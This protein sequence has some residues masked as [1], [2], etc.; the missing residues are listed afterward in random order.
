MVYSAA[1][2]PATKAT[3]DAANSPEAQQ[4]IL[5]LHEIGVK[6]VPGILHPPSTSSANGNLTSVHALVDS[7]I[8]G[9]KCS[10]QK[11]YSTLEVALGAFQAVLGLDTVKLLL[12]D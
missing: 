2:V 7:F 12:K 4:L 9:V 6:V 11:K 1:Q 10:V 5:Q 8:M 3:T